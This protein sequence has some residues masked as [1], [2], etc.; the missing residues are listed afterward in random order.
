M[1]DPP[2]LEK[3]QDLIDSNIDIISGKMV[4]TIQPQVVDMVKFSIDR[5]MGPVM[6]SPLGNPLKLALSP[7]YT[8]IQDGLEA[9]LSSEEGKQR[10]KKILHTSIEAIVQEVTAPKNIAVLQ[11]QMADLLEEV[12]REV[13]EELQKK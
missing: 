10:L 11:A 2:T 7:V 12:K 9:A 5:A 6:E 3:V 8:S 4:P 1:I 13:Q